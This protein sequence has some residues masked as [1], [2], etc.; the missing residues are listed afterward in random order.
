MHLKPIKCAK[1]MK[2]EKH[3]REIVMHRAQCV[4]KER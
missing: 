3:V 1:V 4:Y 2:L